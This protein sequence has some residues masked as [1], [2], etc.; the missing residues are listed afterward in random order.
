MEN[1]MKI[2]VCGPGCAK[3]HEAERLVQETIAENN[4]MAEVEKV[5]DF[6]AIAQLGV[7]TTPAVIVDGMVKCVGKVPTKAELLSWIS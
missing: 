6:N 5:T 4:I 3:C 1:I 7:F 2:Q